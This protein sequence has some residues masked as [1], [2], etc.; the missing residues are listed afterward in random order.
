MTTRRRFTFSFARTGSGRSP[1]CSLRFFACR[2]CCGSCQSACEKARPRREEKKT[3]VHRKRGGLVS[4]RGQARRARRSRAGR[5]RMGITRRKADRDGDET[6]LSDAGR[7]AFRLG[8]NERLDER[9][10]AD[11]AADSPRAERKSG[12]SANQEDSTTVNAID[13]PGKIDG[14]EG[15]QEHSGISG[16]SRLGGQPGPWHIELHGLWSEIQ[17][18]H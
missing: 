11:G 6:N 17:R 8:E 13:K 12:P 16:P 5:A 2:S 14:I 18:S 9:A 3:R 15:R 7:N 4:S 1:I 10:L